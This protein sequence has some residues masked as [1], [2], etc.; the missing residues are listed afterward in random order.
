MKIYTKTGDKG[1]TSLFS[2]GRVLKSDLRIKTYGTV[3]ELNSF[4]G[5]L[6]AC[7]INHAYKEILIKIQ[8]KLYNLGS[9]LAVKGEVK[10]ELPKIEKK[11]I[12][13][14]EN[15]IDELSSKLSPLKDF[16]LP[17]GNK[18]VAQCH[19][20][21][22]VCR[23]AERELVELSQTEKINFLLV[24]Y[25][26]RLSDYLFALSRVLSKETNATETVWQP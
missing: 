22:T 12:E 8:H 16:I 21:R 19:V 6:C 3:D 2:G 9:L 23:R 17:G 26:N 7:E 15:K 24:K 10:Y 4:I 14:L 5:L 13:F 20:C 25:L 18:Q 1:K 11:D